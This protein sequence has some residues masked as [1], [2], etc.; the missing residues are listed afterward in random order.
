[1]SRVLTISSKLFSFK[2]QIHIH[3]EFGERLYEANGESFF[4]RSWSIKNSVE[5]IASINSKT[6]SWSPTWVV[7]SVLGDFTIRRKYFS[8]KRRYRVIGGRYN[9]ALILGNFWDQAFT[10]THAESLIA[11]AKG[12]VLTMRDTHAIVVN[13]SSQSSELF[14]VIVMV[15]LLQDRKKRR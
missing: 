15:T 1:M 3:G 6:W 11:S 4:N 8:W 10:I 7:K 2:G 9:N 13:D 14:T 5:E 12:K